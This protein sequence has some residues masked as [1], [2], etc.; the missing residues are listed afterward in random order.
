[1]LKPYS[2]IVVYNMAQVFAVLNR[3]QPEQLDR[4]QYDGDRLDYPAKP[5]PGSPAPPIFQPH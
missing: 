2:K 3:I 5:L 4:I 1:M